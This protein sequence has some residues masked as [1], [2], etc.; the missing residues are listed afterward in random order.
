MTIKH[1]PLKFVIQ[2][3]CRGCSIE[4][5]LTEWGVSVTGSKHST[6]KSAPKHWPPVMKTRPTKKKTTMVHTIKSC[7]NTKF[8][9]I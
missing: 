9:Q 1:Q 6:D 3:E 2:W 4:T 5:V 7:E 8:N